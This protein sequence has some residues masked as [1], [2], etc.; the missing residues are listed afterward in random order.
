MSVQ[1]PADLEQMFISVFADRQVAKRNII[2]NQNGQPV[3]CK[4]LKNRDN[5]GVPSHLSVKVFDFGDL[6]K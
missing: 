5:Q 1:M 4:I 3:E 6:P 2:E